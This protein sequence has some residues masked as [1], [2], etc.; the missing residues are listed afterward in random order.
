MSPDTGVEQWAN[1][2]KEDKEK[3]IVLPNTLYLAHNILFFKILLL[4][5]AIE[6]IIIIYNQSL[7]QIQVIMS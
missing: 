5:G 6:I 7:T 2:T 1:S 4:V 3:H